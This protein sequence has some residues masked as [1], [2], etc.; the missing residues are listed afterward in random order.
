MA[1]TV[2]DTRRENLRRLLQ[3]RG[4]K[5]ALAVRLGTSQSYISH[6]IRD[7]DDSAARLI[8]EDTARA[9]LT[10]TG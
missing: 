1:D 2:Y 10:S 6:A 7:P 3:H 5:T 8:H 9:M 4:A